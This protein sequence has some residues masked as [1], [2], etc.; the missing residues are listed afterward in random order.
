MAD[1]TV[2]CQEA[3]GTMNIAIGSTS[4]ASQQ[5][6]AIVLTAGDSPTV[7]AVALVDAADNALAYTEG[8]PQGSASA[9]KNGNDYQVSSE[10]VVT[11]LNNPT[12]VQTKPFEVKV[13]CS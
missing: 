3:A 12:S 11:D 9:T 2:V 10:G 1:A 8:I 4:A 5:G 13:S 7:Q 6:F